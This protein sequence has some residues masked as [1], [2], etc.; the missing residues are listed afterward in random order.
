MCSVRCVPAVARAARRTPYARS[1]FPL[2]QLWNGRAPPRRSGARKSGRML[3]SRHASDYRG[4]SVRKPSRWARSSAEEHYLD[5]VG[6]TGSIPVAPTTQ[7]GQR[8][9]CENLEQK[10]AFGGFFCL[11][12]V[13]FRSPRRPRRVFE[14]RSPGQEFPF[15]AAKS[16]FNFLTSP[17]HTGRSGNRQFPTA[18]PLLTCQSR[19]DRPRRSN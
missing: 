9:D 2:W 6:V 5:M 19:P 15:P 12:P 8:R 14:P 10:P 17:G 18:D 16:G 3:A 4:A 1:L 13:H 11:R 7:S